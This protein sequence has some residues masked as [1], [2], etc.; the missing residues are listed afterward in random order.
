M[1]GRHLTGQ[2]G[3]GW[4]VASTPVAA[5]CS[6]WGTPASAAHHAAG[7]L[8]AS[9]PLSPRTNTLLWPVKPAAADGHRY[10]AHSEARRGGGR[11]R[12]DPPHPHHPHLQERQ[13]PGEGWVLGCVAVAGVLWKG[14][15]SRLVGKRTGTQRQR[16]LGRRRQLGPPAAPA[17]G[18]GGRLAAAVCGRIALAGERRAPMLSAPPGRPPAAHAVCADLIRGAKEKQLK[19]KGPVR[20]PTR[21]LKITT[22][23]SPCGNGTNTFGATAWARRSPVAR[24]SSTA[25]LPGLLGAVLGGGSVFVLDVVGRCV[26]VWRPYSAPTPG[27]AAGWGSHRVGAALPP[28]PLLLQIGLRCACTSASSTCTPP[29]RWSSRWA[30]LL[31]QGC[32]VCRRAGAAAVLQR[33]RRCRVGGSATVQGGAGPSPHAAPCVSYFA[34]HCQPACAVC[35]CVPVRGTPRSGRQARKGIYPCAGIHGTPCLPFAA[36]HQHLD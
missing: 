34:L 4:T 1:Q 36:D 6:S 14:R 10:Q 8:T 11:G 15:E 18:G 13:E 29:P 12:P 19:V 26:G 3:S 24:A 5:S 35:Q 17:S 21:V 30:E 9:R 33:V 27:P 28:Y 16:Q 2:L 7:L 32:S 20:M 23:K 22:R 31:P 25:Q